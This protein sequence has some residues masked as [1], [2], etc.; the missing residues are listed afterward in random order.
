MLEKTRGISLNYIKY[1]ETSIIAHVYTEKFGRQSFLI[2]GAR[3]RHTSMKASLFQPLSLLQLEIY[4][5]HSSELQSVKEAMNTPSFTTIPFQVEKTTMAI[6]LAEVTYR[7]IREETPNS[8]LFEYLF[9]AIQ[10]L[11]HITEGIANFH[12]VFLIGLAKFLGF[13]PENNFSA[14]TPIFDLVNGIFVAIVPVH[15]QYIKGTLSNQLSEM[16]S[17]SFENMHQINLSND[18]RRQI[19][20]TL[21]SYYQ[22]HVEGMGQIKSLQVLQEVFNE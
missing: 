1:S 14:S 13:Y 17:T 5:K 12:L 3:G 15:P 4:H 2:K 18:E 21:I 8:G 11:D 16:L 9:H 7:C 6:F 22:Y 20:I 10:I 19:L